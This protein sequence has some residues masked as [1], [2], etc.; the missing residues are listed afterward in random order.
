M[1]DG[2]NGSIKV[3]V[4]IWQLGAASRTVAGDHHPANFTS[5]DLH[6]VPGNIHV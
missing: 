1:H 5:I 6:T 2:Q 4:D 3:G